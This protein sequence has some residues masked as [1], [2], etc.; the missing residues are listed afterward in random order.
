MTPTIKTITLRTNIT[1]HPRD[2]KY[3]RKGL[4]VLAGFEHEALHNHNTDG[5]VQYR[6]P[7]IS[8]RS[9]NGKAVLFGY[10]DEAVFLLLQL[11]QQKENQTIYIGIHK[12]LFSIASCNIENHSLVQSDEAEHKYGIFDWLG[13]NEANYSLWLNTDR[14]AD[15][16]LQLEQILAANILA[17]CKSVQWF[18]PAGSLKIMLINEP[19]ITKTRFKELD[20]LKFDVVFKTNIV[21]PNGIGLGKASAHGFGKLR[22]ISIAPI[23]AAKP[24]KKLQLK[25]VLSEE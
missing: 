12:T 5:S 11:V 4:S 21:L 10:G 22:Q 24:V 23:V 6:H 13:L 18:L 9:E 17:F 3:W 15:R 7:T 25:E 1:L 20:L 14:A 8:Y 16:M 19:T 2:I